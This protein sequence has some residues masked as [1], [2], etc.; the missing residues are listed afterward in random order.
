MV[1]GISGKNVMSSL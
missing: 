1:P